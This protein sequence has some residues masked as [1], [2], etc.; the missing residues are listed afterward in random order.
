MLSKLVLFVSVFSLSAVGM[1]MSAAPSKPTAAADS[2]CVGCPAC[3]T[4][5]DGACEVCHCEGCTAK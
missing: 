3:A 4:A 1:V 2:C 5:C